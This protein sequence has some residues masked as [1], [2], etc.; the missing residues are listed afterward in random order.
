MSLIDIRSGFK[1]EPNKIYQIKELLSEIEKLKTVNTVKEEDNYYHPC[2]VN[3]QSCNIILPPLN[4]VFGIL[5]YK[6]PNCKQT[7]YSM[8]VA[9]ELD[10]QEKYELKVLLDYIDMFAYQQ[11]RPDTN[12]KRKYEYYSPQRPNYKDASKP[13]SLRIKIPDF[14]QKLLCVIYNQK[15][16]PIEPTIENFKKYITHNTKV[17]CCVSVGN[18]WFAGDKYGISYKLNAIKIL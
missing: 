3:G 17:Q 8:H 12:T 6:N 1:I 9:L 4:S 16:E 15:N 2:F 14:K 13:L 5:E 18:V 7:K 10:N 11:Y